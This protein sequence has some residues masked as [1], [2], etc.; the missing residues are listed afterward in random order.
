MPIVIISA[1]SFLL[2]KIAWDMLVFSIAFGPGL[3]VER[4]WPSRQSID[5]SHSRIDGWLQGYWTALFSGIC[6]VLF[7]IF[8]FFFHLSPYI[9]SFFPNA[10]YWRGARFSS[11]Y[12]TRLQLARKYPPTWVLGSID[13]GRTTTT[14]R[15]SIEL[16]T[17]FW[18]L[19]Q[20]FLHRLGHI[21]R[22]YVYRAAG[23]CNLFEAIYSCNRINC[24]HAPTLVPESLTKQ[25]VM[26]MGQLG[27]G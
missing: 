12:K 6:N 5:G 4:E 24:G 14:A 19:A 9:L 13:G 17:S 18:G 11:S 16:R 22:T 20:I 26:V 7:F 23:R 2:C 1:L 25:T 3:E 10:N 8:Y 15:R 27:N 21:P